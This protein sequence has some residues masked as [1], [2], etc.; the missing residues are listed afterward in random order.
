MTGDL[1]KKWKRKGKDVTCGQAWWPILG[2]CSL[3][4]TQRFPIPVLAPSTCPLRRAHNVQIEQKSEAI[5]ETYKMSRAGGGGARTGIENRWLNPSKCTHTQQWVVNIYTHTL[6]I[7]TRRSGQPFMLQRPGS[8]WGFG[9]L[10]KGLTSV[11]VLRVERELVNHFP[12]TIPAG[13][14]TRTHNI[15]VTSPTHYPIGQDFP[16]I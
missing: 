7:H 16:Q 8:S 14:E 12:K 6:W 11:V 3:H 5:R 1:Q 4:L 15:W 9:A 13:P 2:I 10:L